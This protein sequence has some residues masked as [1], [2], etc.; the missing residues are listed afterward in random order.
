MIRINQ[1][2][3]TTAVNKKNNG[4]AES[5]PYEKNRLSSRL[6]FTLIFLGQ[7]SALRTLSRIFTLKETD[8]NKTFAFINGI[9]VLSLLW[10]MFGHVFFYGLF[11]ASNLI[12]VLSWSQ[13]F[14]FQLINSGVLAVDTFF[15]LSG[16]LTAFI[17]VRQATKEKLS[18]HFM[19]VYYLHRYIRLT[20]TFLLVV[21]ISITLTPYF[22]TGPFFPSDQGF[23][24]TGCRDHYWWTSILYIANLVK[25]DDMCLSISWYL[26]NDMQFHWIAPLA[27]I[28]FVLGKK[29]IGFL[30]VALFIFVS[31]GSIVGILLYYPTMPAN[32]LELSTPA[33]SK[34]IRSSVG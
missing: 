1:W 15:V 14:A 9:R 10:V 34:S 11:Y 28:P 2:H 27:L 33:V 22:G 29:R 25:P 8:M 4:H 24:P 31:I 19:I 13:N 17:F 32:G 21:L 3:D 26:H 30:I 23:E 6:A 16:F 5:V 12:D 7:F 18:F 20:P